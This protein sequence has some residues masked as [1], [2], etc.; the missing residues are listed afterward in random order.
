[1]AIPLRDDLFPR[2]IPFITIG[3]I[4]INTAIWMIWQPTFRASE[5]VLLGPVGN[6]IE[7]PAGNAFLLINAAI[8]CELT[9]MRPLTVREVRALIDRQRSNACIPKHQLGTGGDF[10]PAVPNKKVWL[11]PLLSTFFHANFAH[12][13]GNMLILAILGNNVEDRLGHIRYIVLY[14][15][16]GAAAWVGHVAL[17]LDS[18]YPAIGASGA[19]AAVFA[20][21]LVFFPFARILTLVWFPVPLAVYLPAFIPILFWFGLQFTPLLESNVAVW[22]HIGGF[23]GG[24]LLGPLLYASIRPQKLPPVPRGPVWVNVRPVLRS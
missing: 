19:I 14:L 2:R 15:L 13:F 12:L 20:A 23:L 4:V 6:Q 7:V 5:T 17:N 16:G 3:L 11:S 24:V 18:L 10:R 1:M 8:P 22:A 9:Q 21:F